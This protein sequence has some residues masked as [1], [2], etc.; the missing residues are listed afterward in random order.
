MDSFRSLAPRPPAHRPLLVGPP[1][2]H[3]NAQKQRRHRHTDKEWEAIKPHILQLYQRENKTEKRVRDILS[4]KFNFETGCRT[5]KSKVR[6][7]GIEK[8]ERRRGIATQQ[9]LTLFPRLVDPFVTPNLQGTQ[10]TLGA[11]ATPRALWRLW[12][13]QLPWFQFQNDWSLPSKNIC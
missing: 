8:N 5:F 9:S 11:S 3:L 1:R 4:R 13:G 10:W 6:E 12:R 7:W 2:P